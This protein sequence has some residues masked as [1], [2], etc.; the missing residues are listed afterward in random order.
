LGE[1]IYSFQ[2][3]ELGLA[4]WNCACEASTRPKCGP[5]L[6]DNLGHMG[7][8]AFCRRRYPGLGIY[9]DGEILK[10]CGSFSFRWS[11]E[12]M[13]WIADRPM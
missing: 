2:L 10:R 13:A 8:V 4:E 12:K 9:D 1:Q 3:E 11:K 6:S 7:A 5:F